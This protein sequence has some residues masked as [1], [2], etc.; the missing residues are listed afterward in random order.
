ML[1]ACLCRNVI[2]DHAKGY[3]WLRSEGVGVYTLHLLLSLTSTSIY[4]RLMSV[5]DA[6]S[7]SDNGERRRTASFRLQSKDNSPLAVFQVQFEER[8][9]TKACT[10]IINDDNIFENMESFA[11]ELSMPVY[12]LLGNITRATV[13]IT[14][15]EDEPTL[16]F[17]RKTYHVS[18]TDGFLSAPVERK[19]GSS[20]CRQAVKYMWLPTAWTLI[21]YFIGAVQCLSPAV[22]SHMTRITAKLLRSLCSLYLCQAQE[23]NCFQLAGK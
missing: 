10:I 15:T 2:P 14:D 18:E 9:D 4:P 7:G 19:G 17:D 23:N 5:S 21:L 12:A 13:T 1:Q 6:A 20:M 11:V 16:Q 8:E 22:S 3:L